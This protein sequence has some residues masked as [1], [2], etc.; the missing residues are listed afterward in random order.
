MKKVSQLINWIL[1]IVVGFLLYQRLPSILDHFK[2]ENSPAPL[3]KAELLQGGIFDLNTYEKPVVVVFWATWCG[4]CEVELGRIKRMVENQEISG[5]SVLTISSFEERDLVLQTVHSRNYPFQNALD[6]Q[7]QVASI[8]RV[9][10][11]PTIVFIDEH[12]KIQWITTGLSPALEFR[13]RKFLN[14][15]GK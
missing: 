4:P 10:G 11:T 2:A 15:T 3:F 6:P 14:P 8:F 13:V 1:F 7:G 9:A 12:K 5:N